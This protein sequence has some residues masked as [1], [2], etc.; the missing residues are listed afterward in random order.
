M[1]GFLAFY[2]NLDR[3]KMPKSNLLPSWLLGQ[4]DQT[5]FA[6]KVLPNIVVC[7][8]QTVKKTTMFKTRL[9]NQ[10]QTKR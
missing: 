5:D 10:D 3:F 7:Q 8:K 1:F 9:I 6:G 2:Q 4:S